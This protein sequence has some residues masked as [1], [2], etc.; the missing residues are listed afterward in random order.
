VLTIPPKS[1]ERLKL[2]LKMDSTKNTISEI[3]TLKL[4]NPKQFYFIK[5]KANEK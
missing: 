2:E 1:V 3:L 5:I 4:E